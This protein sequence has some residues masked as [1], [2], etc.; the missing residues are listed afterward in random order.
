MLQLRN[1]LAVALP[2]P[3]VLDPELYYLRLSRP[4]YCS[5]AFEL[6]LVPEL[7]QGCSCALPRS[8]LPH[9]TL[10]HINNLVFCRRLRQ[11]LGCVEPHT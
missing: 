11:A 8:H 7:L 4:D 1:R 6:R 3:I 9:L 5:L 10:L 2:G